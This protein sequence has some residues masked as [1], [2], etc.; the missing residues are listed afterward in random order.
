MQNQFWLPRFKS[1]VQ[2]N[3]IKLPASA[4]TEGWLAPETVPAPMEPAVWYDKSPPKMAKFPTVSNVTCTSQEASQTCYQKFMEGYYWGESIEI[5]SQVTCP[6]K[7]CL[8]DIESFF[9][10]PSFEEWHQ[11]KGSYKV[12][13]ANSDKLPFHLEALDK[14][15]WSIKA[16]FHYTGPSSPTL[17]FKPVYWAQSVW[18]S[19]SQSN[20]SKWSTHV[21]RVTIF[22]PIGNNGKLFG[23]FGLSNGTFGS[24]LTFNPPYHFELI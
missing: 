13:R 16:H 4:K 20:K 18:I 21:H 17:W 6:R 12:N 10:L 2:P 3:L 15:R 9:D 22:H 5:N 8:I 11:A 7:L 19:N 1:P 23:I 24:E 14:G